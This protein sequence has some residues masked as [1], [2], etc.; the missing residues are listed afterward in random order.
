MNYEIINNDII[1]K[2]ANNFSPEAILTS[3]QVFRFGENN[4]TWWVKSGGEQ[5][6]ICSITPNSYK[7]SCTNAKFFVN[8]FDFLTDYDK[9][10]SSLE[11]H[12]ELNDCLKY[13]TGIRMLKQPLLEVII[14][15]IISANNNIPRIRKSVEGLCQRFGEQTEW[16]FAFPTLEKLSQITSEDF[17]QLNC[18]YRSNYLVKTIKELS[19]TNILQELPKMDTENARKTLI[20]LSGIGP[21]VADCIL[22]FGLNKTDVFPVDTWVEKI[23]HQDYFGELNNRKK[24]AEF[25]VKKYGNLSGY[26]QQFLFYYKRKNISLK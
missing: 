21:K 15:F 26:A 25:F 1:V 5:A 19:T 4:G 22:L 7:I 12:C 14:N 13:G 16:G 17:M 23:Y 2:D 10:I 8:Y 20:K 18:G 11:E 9:I 6:K 24:I 3:G